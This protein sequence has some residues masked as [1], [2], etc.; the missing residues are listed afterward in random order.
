MSLSSWWKSLFKKQ[1]EPVRTEPWR[2]EERGHDYRPPVPP[3][4]RQ[5]QAQAERFSRPASAPVPV[6]GTAPDYLTRQGYA[7]GY[8]SGF[9]QDYDSLRADQAELALDFASAE[10]ALLRDELDASHRREERAEEALDDARDHYRFEDDHAS[11]LREDHEADQ[12]AAETAADPVDDR[13]IL[14]NGAV[15]PT[16]TAYP[17][18]ES[19][20]EPPKTDEQFYG[21]DADFYGTGSSTP[22][23]DPTPSP[24]YESPSSYSAPDPTPSYESPST[25]YESPSSSSDSSN[26]GGSDY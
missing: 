23:P 16:Y 24:S 25:S 22:A 18:Q 10:S 17:P 12:S 4:L 26:Y 7:Q 15:D 21:R 1:Q 8:R 5:A 20:P 19:T 11:H 3:R 6:R 14:P 13:P 2:V 9:G